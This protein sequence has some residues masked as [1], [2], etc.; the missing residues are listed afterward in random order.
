MRATC[1]SAVLMVVLSSLAVGQTQSSPQTARQALIE[2]FF[3]QTANHL[4]KH[5]PDL[6][7]R[8]FKKF[9]SGSGSSLLAEIS[10]F[11]TQA[12]ANGGFATFD[13]GPTLLTAE[14]TRG[15]SSDKMEITVERD[16][17]V[18]D[19]DQI[20]VALHLSKNGQEQALPF[21]P[22]ITFVL[23]T[24][25]EVWRLNEI[26][27]S[28]RLPLADP[29]F[30]KNMEDQ[31]RS[32]NEQMTMASLSTVINAENAYRDR[33]GGYACKLSTLAASGTAGGSN[34]IYFDPE[35]AA[36]KKNGYVFAISGCDPLHYK[37]VAEPAV[38]DSG[39]RAFCSDESG[40]LRA[41]GDG[42]AT[43]CLSRGQPL[44]QQPY[45]LTAPGALERQ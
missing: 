29:D 27:V 19:E 15:G 26:S 12:K 35:L 45:Q 22:R 4:E 2:M 44:E 39:E 34:A 32:R 8:S 5:L 10:M 25:A 14:D 43:T 38:G 28:V 16:D 1:G 11:A 21:V 9:D 18:G 36:G 30:L 17:L 20:E 3:G 23:K 6:T 42:K 40:A 13:T 41:A 37:V 24:E 7:R 33:N 31:E